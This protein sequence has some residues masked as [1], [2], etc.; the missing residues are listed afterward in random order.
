MSVCVCHTDFP[1]GMY[2]DFPWGTVLFVIRSYLGLIQFSIWS[3]L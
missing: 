3:L 2:P 1:S